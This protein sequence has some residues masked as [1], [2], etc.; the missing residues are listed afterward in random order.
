MRKDK[1]RAIALRKSG[2]SYGQISEKLKVSRSTLSGWFGSEDWS[3]RIR[4][5]LTDTARAKQSVQMSDLNRVRGVNLERAYEDARVEAREEFETLKYNPL[6]IAAVMIYWGEGDRVTKNHVRV[7]NTDPEMLKL[8]RLFFM[9]VC[10]IPESRIKASL[11]VYP[12]L[13]EVECRKYWVGKTGIPASSF[14]K[15]TLIAGRHKTKRS[16]NGVCIL[17]ISSTY[18]KEKMMV[19]LELLPKELMSRAYY[20]NM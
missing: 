5:K 10:N 12:D 13:D 4:Q 1:E 14:T 18:L 6:F 7:S 9:K 16:G 3:K 20:E 8:L 2:E 17:V 11:L 19:W 15:S